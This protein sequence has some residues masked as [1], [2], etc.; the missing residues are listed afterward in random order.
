MRLRVLSVFGL[1]SLQDAGRPGFRRFGVPTG[2]A[3]DRESHRLANAMLGVPPDS[4]V[5]EF[6]LGTMEMEAL[7]DGC[8]AVVGACESVLVDG[9]DQGGNV[10]FCFRAG[11][12][13]TVTPPKR[14]LRTFIALPGGVASPQVLESASGA[15]VE[16]GTE[17]SSAAQ[18][19]SLD[20]LRLA[21]PPASLSPSPLRVVALGD[22]FGWMGAEY[23]VG[24][25][26]DRVGLRLEGPRPM[27]EVR[28][29]RSEPSVFGVVQLTEDRSVIVHGPDGPTIGGYRKL[30]GVVRADL[31]RL[32]QLAPGDRVRFVPCTLDEARTAMRAHEKQLGS[33]LAEVAESVYRAG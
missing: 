23:T 7:A 14:G 31:D 28:S 27:V 19:L 8:V 6:A 18:A 24:R 17:I 25:N 10:R 26:I 33:A 15:V 1:A 30:G 20:V 13:L 2:G 11:S 4:P 12:R 32:A 22:D 3:F 21:R 5:V 16:A 9:N 29:G